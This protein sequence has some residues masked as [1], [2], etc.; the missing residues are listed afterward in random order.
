MIKAEGLKAGY[1]D[2]KIEGISLE[3]P[4]GSIC[5]LAGPNASGKTT[6]LKA[7]GGLLPPLEG[8]VLVNGTGIHSLSPQERGRLVSYVPPEFHSSFPFTVQEMVLMG[9]NP[10]R[11]RFRGHGRKDLEEAGKALRA[12]GCS[13]FSRKSINRLSSGQRQLALIARA[14]CQQ[15]PVMLLDEPAS[16]LDIAQTFRIYEILKSIA[17]EG[18]TVIAVT[19]DLGSAAAYSDRIILMKDGRVRG[20]GRPR[21]VIR[22]DLLEETYGEKFEVKERDGR[23]FVRI[24]R[25]NRKE[26]KSR[27]CGGSGGEIPPADRQW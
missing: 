8:K 1:R 9:R 11:G 20:F 7:A 23:L 5:V 14:I 24:E 2:F 17:S 18:R 16:H 12:A 3:V 27:N 21:E 10:Y 25:R 4:P 15:T 19:H 13:G 22:E 26:M 6:F